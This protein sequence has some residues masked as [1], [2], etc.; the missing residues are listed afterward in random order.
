M[1]LKV[2]QAMEYFAKSACITR[3]MLSVLLDCQVVRAMLWPDARSQRYVTAGDDGTIAL[4]RSAATGA[5]P[6]CKAP[7]LDP[8]SKKRQRRA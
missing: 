5:P 8:R 1:F 7:D 4:W 3:S 6:E 2:C